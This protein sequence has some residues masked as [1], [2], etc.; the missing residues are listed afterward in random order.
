MRLLASPAALRRQGIMGMNER[1]VGYIGKFNPR[2]FYPLVDNKLETKRAAKERGLPVP[3]LYG[4]VEYQY[5]VRDVAAKLESLASFVIKPAQGSGG[6]GILV[7]VGRNGD[8]YIKSSGQEITASDVRRHVS[9]VLAGLH[10]LGGRNDIA[11]IEALIDFDPCLA[12]YSYEGVPDIRVIAFR[13]VPV[14]AMMRCATHD[15]DGKANLHQGAVGVGL[16]VGTGTAVRA[17]QHGQLVE[18]HPDTGACFKTLAI[19]HWER[20]LDMAASCVEMTGLQYIGADVVLDKVRGPMLLELNA[21][22]GL[23]IQVANQAG[24]RE[25]LAIAA[26]IAEQT[27]E[28]HARIA[29]AR[30]RFGE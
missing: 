17:V 23:A 12:Q 10:S 11:M 15:S 1:N 28:H 22:P 16:N 27:D 5:E 7:V 13:G 24:L 14:M 19:P 26:E 8:R 2:R 3:E 30:Q 20:V 25:R 18:T 9:N 6:K 21:R 4:V 29:L